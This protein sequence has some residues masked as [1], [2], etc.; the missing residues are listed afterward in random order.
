M[1]ALC[2]LGSL[3]LRAEPTD[4]R[5]GPLPSVRLFLVMADVTGEHF[6]TAGKPHPSMRLFVMPT[7]PVLGKRLP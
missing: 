7:H 3:F 1:H 2:I 6:P 4:N 5:L